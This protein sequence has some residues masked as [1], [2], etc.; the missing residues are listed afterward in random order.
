[1]SK[2]I[3]RKEMTSTTDG[4]PVAFTIEDAQAILIDLEDADAWIAYSQNDLN[5]DSRRFK[6]V[7]TNEPFIIPLI[8]P[9]SGTIWAAYTAAATTNGIKVW[10]M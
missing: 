3:S 1:M 6:L 7:R 5:I 9:W 4:N 10:V 8:V 2:Y